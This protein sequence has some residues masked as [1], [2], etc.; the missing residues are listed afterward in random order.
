M[1]DTRGSYPQ[2]SVGFSLDLIDNVFYDTKCEA[3]DTSVKY[4]VTCIVCREEI[5]Q[6]GFAYFF[7]TGTH[8]DITYDHRYT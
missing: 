1:D 8:D 5:Y 7:D 6:T 3:Y 2:S 4:E